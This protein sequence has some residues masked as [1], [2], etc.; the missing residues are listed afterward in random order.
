MLSAVDVPQVMVHFVGVTADDLH[1]PEHAELGVAD[2]GGGWR[3]LRGGDP[4]AGRGPER[5]QA[6]TGDNWW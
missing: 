5:D 6:H 1:R 4:L 2:V 3:G